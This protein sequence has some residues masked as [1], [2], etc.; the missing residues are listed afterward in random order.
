MKIAIPF[1]VAMLFATA[2]GQVLAPADIP[3][4]EL[5]RMGFNLTCES[6]PCN[7]T[8][9]PLDDLTG[10]VASIASLYLTANEEPEDD[11][12]DFKL[13]VK[14]V[15]NE[16]TNEEFTWQICGHGVDCLKN[17]YTTFKCP[18]ETPVWITALDAW[19]FNTS[20]T[21]G[22]M[23]V[24]AHVDACSAEVCT[25]PKNESSKKGEVH[26][27]I[28]LGAMLAAAF[29]LFIVW[30]NRVGTRVNRRRHH[31]AVNGDVPMEESPTILKALPN[32]GIDQTPELVAADAA[33][34]EQS[35]LLP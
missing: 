16:S 17:N 35:K 4:E 26:W 19:R 18:Y 13:Y 24:H 31:E 23:F 2:Q 32:P 29:L 33:P 15:G 3:G 1:T 27:A 14:C 22:R 21:D 30:I 28:F 9:Q 6:A 25:T 8:S 5:I 7:V 11:H 34:A 12:W 20:T 10:P